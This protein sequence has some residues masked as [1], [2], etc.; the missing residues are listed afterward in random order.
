MNCTKKNIWGFAQNKPTLVVK[1][2]IEKYPDVDPEFIYEVLL[3]RGVFKWLAV[4]RDLIK[5]KE[6]WRDEVAKLNKKK[7]QKEKGYHKALIECRA[8]IRKL[9]H[10]E[11]FRAPDFDR[12]ANK[13][14]EKIEG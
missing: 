5:L 14:L 7:T 6:T 1:D 12:G 8:E 10:S 3:K 4:R 2:I 9:C 11:R 13:Y